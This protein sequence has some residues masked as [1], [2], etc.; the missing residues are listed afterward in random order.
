[1]LFTLRELFCH[2]LQAGIT[3]KRVLNMS[4]KTLFLPLLLA[5]LVVGTQTGLA[6]LNLPDNTRIW[7]G[8][9]GNYDAKDAVG[10]PEIELRPGSVAEVNIFDGKSYLKSV[11]I[12]YSIELYQTLAA[13]LRP[14]DLFIGVRDSQPSYSGDVQSSSG[15]Y[16]SL[17]ETGDWSWVV[18]AGNVRDA[19]VSGAQSWGL[20]DFD[21]SGTRSGFASIDASPYVMSQFPS[22]DVS[23]RNNHPYYAK[24][25]ALG[26]FISTVGVGQFNTW[27]TGLEWTLTFA[28]NGLELANADGTKYLEVGFTVNCAN[29]VLDSF[30]LLPGDEGGGFNPVPE[31]ATLAIWSLLGGVG[32]A[33]SQIRRRKA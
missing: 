2:A 8:W 23:I 16:L 33:A 5:I 13:D 22:S 9:T 17:T 12:K 4:R 11:T 27:G 31:P 3:K 6:A 20:Y 28:G 10:V 29:D 21:Y 32:M 14:G 30:V 18:H 1:M 24:T 25:D 26:S 7:S 19:T 15:T